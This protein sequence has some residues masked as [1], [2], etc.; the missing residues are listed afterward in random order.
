V[1]ATFQGKFSVGF[2]RDK[3]TCR[4]GADSLNDI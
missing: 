1:E 4:R 3:G 2:P